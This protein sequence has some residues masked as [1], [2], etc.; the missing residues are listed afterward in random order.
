MMDNVLPPGPLDLDLDLERLERDP[1]DLRL[2]VLDDDDEEDSSSSCSSHMH[3][4]LM[5]VASSPHS[6]EQ[7][8]L[9]VSIQAG[10]A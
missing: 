9:M 4:L 1:E 5:Q 3:W 10:S 6:G 8:P 7:K 2:E